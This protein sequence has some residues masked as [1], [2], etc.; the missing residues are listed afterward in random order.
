MR[1]REFITLV[2]GAAAW[3]LVANAQKKPAR[4]GFLGAGGATGMA[5]FVEALKDG[6]RENGLQEGR[7]YVFDFGWAEG[8]YDMFPALAE[9]MV[10]N[11]DAIIVATTISAVRAAQLA[12]NKIPIVMASIIDPVGAKLVESLARP[13]GN[14]TGTANLAEDVNT[15]LVE[16]MQDLLPKVNK[17]GV[18]LNPANPLNPVILAK[19][20]KLLGAQAVQVYPAE[21]R[22]RQEFDSAFAALERERPG[23][24]FIMPDFLLLDA[25]ERI[26]ALAL[27]YRIP[28]IT[29]QP[30]YTDAGALISYGPSR[31]AV[32]RR[33]AY[34]VKRILDGANPADLPVEQPTQMELSINLK[35]AKE[36]GISIPYGFLS[37]ADRVVE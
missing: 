34:Y 31:R 2:S 7:D 14:T 20:E 12:S 15:K 26:A 17:A 36:L 28:V 1:R 23:A 32:Y 22:S 11:N 21:T 5:I 16:L 4:I 8:D 10:K 13:G 19:L 29:N 35:T 6:L 24:L 33:S 37:R 9:A 18:L 3:P 30:E 25:R 27:R